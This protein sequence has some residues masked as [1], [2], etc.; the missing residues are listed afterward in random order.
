[1]LL[2]RR[3]RGQRI[4][5]G[6]QV[7]VIVVSTT[8]KGARLA[9][10]AP[11]GIAVIR[12]ESF[13]SVHN[14]SKNMRLEG[15]RFGTL[16]IDSGSPIEIE[17]GMVGFPGSTSYVLLQSR[18]T[19]FGWLQS[20]DRPELAF[21]VVDQST[22]HGDSA[23][24]TKAEIGNNGADKAVFFVVAQTDGGGLVA[25]VLAPVVIDMTTRRGAQVILDGK[26]YS[27]AE[28]LRIETA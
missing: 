6:N 19:G 20:I 3:R 5:I 17:G 11:K 7:E 8:K 4:V 26:K 1:M 14:V 2:V 12:G 9:I 25:N 23:L 18:G 16:E 10:V 24:P 27:A 28:P 22:V 13:D 15:T 21:P